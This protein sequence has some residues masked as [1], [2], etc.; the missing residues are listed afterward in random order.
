MSVAVS[1]SSK[2]K[3]AGESIYKAGNK[4]NIGFRMLEGSNV[5]IFF[6]PVTCTKKTCNL[7]FS[8]YLVLS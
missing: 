7:S 5:E 6:K 1:S 8:Y 2:E 3:K 4:G